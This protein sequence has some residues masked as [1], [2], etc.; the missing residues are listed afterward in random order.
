MVAL[1]EAFITGTGAFLPGEPVGNDRMEDFI[2]RV[3]GRTSTVGQRALRWNGIADPPL[4]ADAG[5]RAA[6]HQ[7]LD[8]RGGGPRGAR[9]C[10]PRTRGPAAARDR[11]HAGRLSRAGPRQRR[12]RRAR[13]RRARTGELPVGLRVFGDGGQGRLAR[14]CAPANTDCAVAVAERIL[15]ALVPA[16]LLRGHGADRR[17]GPAARWRP[18][19]CAGP[20]RTAPARSWSSRNRKPDGRALRIDWIDLTSLAGRFDP[21]MWAG[22]ARDVA[23][24]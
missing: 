1:R 24:T 23:P 9:R 21:C 11:D 6:A 3:G 15:L 20:C 16:E 14:R 18:I 2:G 22:A 13:R 17:Q 10:R 4:R 12:A 19:S 7:C 5:R 8:G